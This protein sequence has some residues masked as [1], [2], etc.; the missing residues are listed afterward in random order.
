MTYI[1][2][3]SGIVSLSTV[4]VV[5]DNGTPGNAADDFNATY[6][7][8]DTNSNGQLD[9][10]ET[11]T[12]TAV[13]TV[14]PGQTTRS[15]KATGTAST[16]TVTK[17]EVTNYFGSVPGIA[18]ESFISGQDADSAPGPTLAA[19][20]STPFTYVLSNSGNIALTNVVVNDDNGTPGNAADDFS[21]TLATGDTNGNN[22]LDIGET[23][24]YSANRTTNFGQIS[25]SATVSAED[26][27]GQLVNAVD[28]LNYFGSAPGIDLQQSVNGDDADSVPGPTLVAGSTA[29]FTYTLTNTGNVPLSDVVV[30]DD[31]GSAGS[32]GDDFSP[33][34]VGGDTNGNNLLD[35]DETWTYSSSRLAVA[36]QV[37]IN[38]RVSAQDSVNQT[39]LSFDGTNYFVPA[40]ADFNGDTVVDSGDY[41]MWRKNSG[42]TSGAVLGQGDANGD[43]MVDG[44]DYD[45]WRGQYNTQI[46]AGGGTA[47]PS[48]GAASAA[49]LVESSRALTST[50]VAAEADIRERTSQASRNAAF[51]ELARAEPSS[52]RR[53]I[54]MPHRRPTANALDSNWYLLL[55]DIAAQKTRRGPV[56]VDGDLIDQLQTEVT[57]LPPAGCQVEP[58]LM[59]KGVTSFVS[60]N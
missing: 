41:V 25:H 39:T 52:A 48:A 8:G 59:D 26:S 4:S 10:G 5:D 28:A 29:T 6:S 49:N 32:P 37:F 50:A 21:P 42:I 58:K 54:A 53:A 22:L 18:I 2:S 47:T 44:V 35:V 19:F 13:R 15:G 11:W 14:V 16:T 34:F 57:E 12:F 30:T 9:V 60:E 23:W 31:N 51:A 3:N 38:S 24:I 36:G 7:S 33:T 45:F 1:V 27:A 40:N 20:A 46:D 55:S 56:V 17:S 43:G